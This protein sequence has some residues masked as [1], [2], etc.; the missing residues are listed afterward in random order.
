MARTCRRFSRRN[1]CFSNDKSEKVGVLTGAFK[2]RQKVYAQ[3][4]SA[5]PAAGAKIK[6]NY[7]E[8]KLAQVGSPL[9]IENDHRN[10]LPKNIALIFGGLEN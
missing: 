4:R 5:K 9:A 10:L 2:D 3:A 7:Q 1:K 8:M 6:L